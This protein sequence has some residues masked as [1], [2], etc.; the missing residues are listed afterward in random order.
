MVRGYM[1]KQPSQVSYKK[2]GLKNIAKIH[3]KSPFF[4]KIAAQRHKKISHRKIKWAIWYD[5]SDSLEK[6]NLQK[7]PI[8]VK[9]WKKHD[10]VYLVVK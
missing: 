4:N 2:A 6:L 1:Q 7:A 8:M 5:S 10:G 3:K 9:I